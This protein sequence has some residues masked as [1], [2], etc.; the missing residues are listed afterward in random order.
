M[1]GGAAPEFPPRIRLLMEARRLRVQHAERAEILVLWAKAIASSRDARLPGISLD[2]ALRACY[3]A[4][5]TACHAILATRE[6]RTTSGPG[7]HEVTFA[8]V[9]ALAL[10]GLSDLVPDSE[11]IRSLRRGSVYDAILAA[12]ADRVKAIAWMGDVL[13]RVR[14]ALVTWDPSLDRDL[15]YSAAEGRGSA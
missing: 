13:P 5:L 3:D 8:A 2:G 6:L 11:E 12:E 10:P 4:A 14:A 7:H 9:E 15:E 1:S